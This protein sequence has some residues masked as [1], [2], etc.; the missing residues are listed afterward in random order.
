[1][2]WKVQIKAATLV[3]SMLFSGCTPVISENGKKLV[4]SNAPFKEI[5]A[6]PGRYIS[7][8][9]MLGGRIAAV[10][11]SNEGTYLEIVQF[12]LS[13]QSVPDDSFIS[14]GRFLGYTDSF[15]DPLIYEKG[16]LIT[17]VGEIKGKIT[18]RLDNMDYTYPLLT[19]REWKLLKENSFDC[20]Y[21][22]NS[23]KYDPNSY[24]Y[25]SEPFFQRTYVPYPRP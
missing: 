7:K 18:R 5:Q 14:Y 12:D 20:S 9:I 17:L 16:T 21:P 11:N 24:G 13:S 3:L 6:D 2:K 8:H 4:D 25:G 15:L 23:A 22:P 10:T 1:M 19:M